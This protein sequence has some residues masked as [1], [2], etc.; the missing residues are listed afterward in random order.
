MLLS[1]G[2]ATSVS[3][4]FCCLSTILS[5]RTLDSQS[6]SSCSTAITFGGV[7]LELNS[8]HTDTHTHTTFNYFCLCEDFDRQNVLFSKIKVKEA[9]WQTLECSN[10]PTNPTFLS[11]QKWQHSGSSWRAWQP[12]N[13]E[14][15]TNMK[16]AVCN[17][18]RKSITWYFVLILW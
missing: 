2:V 1:P 9:A 16:N 5:L 4:V 14:S 10:F 18:Y 17:R 3:T 6:S 12:S 13:W 8:S 7:T 11:L 15:G